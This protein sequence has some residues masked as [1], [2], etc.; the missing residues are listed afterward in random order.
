MPMCNFFP[1]SFSFPEQKIRPLRIE[2]K[3][4]LLCS[5]IPGKHETYIWNEKDYYDAIEKSYFVRT[6]K[7]AG[8]DCMRHY[9]ILGA[10]SVP[11]FTDIEH[12]PEKVMFQLPRELLYEANVLYHN[13]SLSGITD[14]YKEQYQDLCQRFRAHFEQHLTCRRM[15]EYVLTTARAQDT[16]RI[17]YLSPLCKLHPDYLRDM[18]LIGFKQIM[19]TNCHDYPKIQHIYNNTTLDPNTLYGKGISYYKTVD[20]TAR[21]DSLDKTIID[22]IR[23]RKYDLIVYGVAYRP[24]ILYELIEKYYPPERIVLLDGDDES[25]CFKNKQINDRHYYFFRELY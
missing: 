1:I 15:A 17:L 4:D 10:G 3:T 6:N 13:M 25:H 19:G 9:E 24:K 16:R 23:A 18:T 11:L 14:E 20:F 7:K 8:W 2:E 5:I 21:D 22:D 12:A